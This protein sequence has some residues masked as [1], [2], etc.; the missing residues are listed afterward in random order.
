MSAF[1]YREAA[2]MLNVGVGTIR[3]RV[4]EGWLRSF[5]QGTGLTAPNLIPT[6]D[7]MKHVRLQRTNELWSA[8][9]TTADYDRQIRHIEAT[10]KRTAEVVGWNRIGEVAKKFGIQRLGDLEPKD[11]THYLADLRRLS[12]ML[13]ATAPR[14]MRAHKGFV[15]KPSTLP[16]LPP[17]YA[18]DP[19]LAE[20]LGPVKPR[21]Q[22]PKLVAPPPSWGEE[23][24]ELVQQGEAAESIFGPVAIGEFLN[25]FGINRFREVRPSQLASLKAGLARL[26]QGR[27]PYVRN[28]GVSVAAEGEERRRA[29]RQQKQKRVE[30]RPRLEG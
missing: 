29:K 7:V 18:N 19:R 9:P 27:R 15:P 30:A 14:G 13:K 12:N 1:T 6:E 5:K 17:I 28:F 11:F 16:E 25:R 10:T 22:A 24:R 20:M 3:R 21:H 23:L 4:A 26:A 2:K 8:V